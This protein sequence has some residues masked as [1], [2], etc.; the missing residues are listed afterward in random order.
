MLK[1]KEVEL[2][3]KRGK[4]ADRKKLAS[5]LEMSQFAV[6]CFDEDVIDYKEQCYVILMNNNLR[7]N[8]W[9]RV[10]DGGLNE[11]LVDV[12]IIMQA[13]LLSNSTCIVLVHNHPSGAVRPSRDDDRLT[14]RVKKACDIMNIRLI[15]HI[16]VTSDATYYSYNDEGRL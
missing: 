10:S 7:P 8:G 1:A 12:R 2:S 4:N 15:D 13:A 9:Y 14:D 11:T 3:Y 16:I 5:S 6:K